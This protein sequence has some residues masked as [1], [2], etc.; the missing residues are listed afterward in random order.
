MSC[1]PTCYVRVE[2]SARLELTGCNQDVSLIGDGASASSTQLEH[3]GY[4]STG[5]TWWTRV[6]EISQAYEVFRGGLQVLRNND[7]IDTRT[8]T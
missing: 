8:Q 7:S 3:W 4:D 1:H 5:D 2:C 6:W